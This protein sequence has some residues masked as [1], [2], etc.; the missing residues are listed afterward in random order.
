MVTVP[1][2]IDAHVS[3]N[4]HL[5]SLH[6]KAYPII[7][8]QAKGAIAICIIFDCFDR[9]KAFQDDYYYSTLLYD[10][11]THHHANCDRNGNELSNP[12]TMKMVTSMK[13]DLL[14]LQIALL[15]VDDKR[16]L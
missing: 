14:F 6:F 7:I 12:R 4:D 3:S 10:E 9:K 5:T 8:V 1:M 2:Y 11:E 13:T 15:H 16:R